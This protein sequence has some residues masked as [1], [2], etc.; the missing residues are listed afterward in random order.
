MALPQ[1]KHMNSRQEL[2]KLSTLMSKT[3]QASLAFKA[4]KAGKSHWSSLLQLEGKPRKGRSKGCRKSSKVSVRV[5]SKGDDISPYANMRDKMK[6]T[7]RCSL[8]NPVYHG[9]VWITCSGG[10]LAADTE[11]CFKGGEAAEEGE[12]E[13]EEEEEELEG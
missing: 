2:E 1:K 7:Y 12:E 9:V 3:E 5:G 6:E 11:R 13:G 4:C 8:V 10:K